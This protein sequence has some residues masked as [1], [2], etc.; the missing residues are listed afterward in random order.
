MLIPV[1]I[2]ASYKIPTSLTVTLENLLGSN[3]PLL[4]PEVEVMNRTSSACTVTVSGEK[5]NVFVNSPDPDFD[6][7]VLSPMFSDFSVADGLEAALPGLNQS[8]VPPSTYGISN[9]ITLL[10]AGP[11]AEVWVSLVIRGMIESSV[12]PDKQTTFNV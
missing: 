8:L 12:S 7:A 10:N 5:R 3:L 4:F 11:A 2:R 1:V 6:G 9:E